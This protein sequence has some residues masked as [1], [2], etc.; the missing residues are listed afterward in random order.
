MKWAPQN[1][2][3]IKDS[4]CQGTEARSYPREDWQLDFIHISVL[5]DMFTGWVEAFSCSTESAKE[6]VWVLITEIIPHFGLPKSLQSDNGP[7]F[8]AEVTQGLSR[9]L[10]L[11]YHLH[12]AWCPQSSGKVEKTNELLKRHLAKLAQE[13]H[14]P[15]TKLLPTSLIRLRNTPGMRGQTP[16]ESLYGSPFLIN[17]LLLDQKTAYLISHIT[18]L[19]KFQ[20]TLLKTKQATPR[21]NIKGPPLFCPSDLVLIKSPNPTVT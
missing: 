17:D 2:P 10:G 12:C 14:S 11:E 1:T 6:V 7:A 21:E 16:F 8:K 9:A 13:I 20:Q 15:W 5:V 3:I 19:A 18:Q 4:K